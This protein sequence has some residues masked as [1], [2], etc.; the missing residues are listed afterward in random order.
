MGLLDRIRA[1]GGSS[2]ASSV[3]EAEKFECPH[4]TLT[5]Q[6]AE[7]AD[8]GD[9]TTATGFHCPACDTDFTPQQADWARKRG[10]EGSRR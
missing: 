7:G 8:E 4:V 10:L 3:A 5:P 2:A 1:L 9:E 6:W